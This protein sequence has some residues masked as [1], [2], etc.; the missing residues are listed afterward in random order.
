MNIYLFTS[1]TCVQRGR[2]QGPDTKC[3]DDDRRTDDGRNSVPIA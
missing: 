2:V 1:G 3:T